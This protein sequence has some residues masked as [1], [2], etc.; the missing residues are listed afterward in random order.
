MS[1][2]QI[3]VLGPAAFTLPRST[4]GLGCADVSTTRV[5]HHRKTRPEDSPVFFKVKY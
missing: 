4:I 3:A 5:Y 1:H 2:Y